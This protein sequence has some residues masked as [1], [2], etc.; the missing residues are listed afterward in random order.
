MLGAQQASPNACVAQC[1][2]GLPGN[3]ASLLQLKTSVANV[4][5]VLGPA[6]LAKAKEYVKT[7]QSGQQMMKGIV[8][9]PASSS[10]PDSDVIR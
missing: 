1:C 3:E 4:T 7:L 9:Y 8:D 5:A 10:N 2:G 6:V